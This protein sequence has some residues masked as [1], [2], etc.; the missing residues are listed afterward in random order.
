MCN[1]LYGKHVSIPIANITEN[2]FESLYFDESFCQNFK[3]KLFEI[4]RDV[5]TEKIAFENFRKELLFILFNVGIIGVKKPDKPLLF[6][7]D[8]IEIVTKE[9][10]KIGVKISTHKALYSY[11]KTNTREQLEN[12]YTS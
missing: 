5:K 1:F 12:A 8:P 3:G 2:D 10:F 11:F 7:Y 9:D 6:Y 4:C